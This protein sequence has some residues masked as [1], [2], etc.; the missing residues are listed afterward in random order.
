MYKKIMA[1][2]L[3]IMLFISGCGNQT[4][5]NAASVE[6][7]QTEEWGSFTK[8]KTYSYDEKYYAI[9]DV[10]EDSES[11]IEYVYVTVYDGE[12]DEEISSFAAERASDFWG[13]CW[14]SDTYNIWIQSS[15]T[16]LACYQYENGKWTR[17]DAAEKPA[18]II[19]KYDD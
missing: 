13:I 15:D 19:S 9:Q 5:G 12:K 17:N 10:K 16:G 2:S 18:D 14:E 7:T 6:T 11:G 8:D 1:L 4:D 3:C